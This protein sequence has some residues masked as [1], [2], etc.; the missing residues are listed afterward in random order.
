[1]TTILACAVASAL[2]AYSEPPA[3]AEP[4]TPTAQSQNLAADLGVLARL[5]K[6]FAAPK[7]YK[8][9]T[10]EDV[11]KDIKA[12]TGLSC[13]VDRRAIGEAGGWQLVRIDCEPSSPRAALDMVAR[14][15]SPDY[16]MYFVD[17]ASGLVVFTDQSGRKSLRAPRSYDL[18]QAAAR[19][20]GAGDGEAVAPAEW[21][22]DTIMG[23]VE[24]ELWDEVGGDMASYRLAGTSATIVAPPSMHHAIGQALANISAT[25]PSAQIEWRVVVAE[26][27]AAKADSDEMGAALGSGD[28]RAL[29]AL[30]ARVLATPRLLTERTQP[31]EIAIGE[32]EES[33]IVRIAPEGAPAAR[34][35]SV[36]C[37]L[38]R[39]GASTTMAF[40]TRDGERAWAMSNRGKD[41]ALA[42]FVSSSAP[43]EASAPK[44]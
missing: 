36:R 4:A 38:T 39:E 41:N 32:A 19:A 33:L 25:L 30:G 2:L 24:P 8:D 42:V 13:D 28:T 43:K 27:P 10:V 15:I 11:L 14:A 40:R 12:E 5:D 35:F 26:I 16:Q 44:E 29:E 34:G 37:N 17:V 21:V 9:A 20:R 6:P 1:M 18:S 7:Q 31:A 23:S 22:M 3:A